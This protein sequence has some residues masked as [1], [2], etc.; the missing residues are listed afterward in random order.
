MLYKREDFEVRITRNRWGAQVFK[1]VDYNHN[2]LHS[3]GS[4]YN[5]GEYWPTREHAEQILDEYY[6]KP[7]HVWKN[8]DVFKIQN[9]PMMCLCESTSRRV[10]HLTSGHMATCSMESY[11]K[12]A[13]FLFNIK[14][15]L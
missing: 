3:D 8:G 5:C 6:P 13:T 14:D 15:K 12:D 9:F 7:K 4:V 1:I 10:Y 2:Y 11:L